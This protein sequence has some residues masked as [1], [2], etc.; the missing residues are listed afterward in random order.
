[1][2]T[3]KF[4]NEPPEH[5]SVLVAPPL[6][7]IAMHFTLASVTMTK[8]SAKLRLGHLGTSVELL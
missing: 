7:H 2:T 4:A 5:F 3:H 8:V 1:M 6:Q